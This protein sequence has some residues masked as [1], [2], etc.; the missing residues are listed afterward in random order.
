MILVLYKEETDQDI[1][2]VDNAVQG[3]GVDIEQEDAGRIGGS[4]DVVL[5]ENDEGSVDGEDDK[6]RS[7]ETGE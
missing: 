2:M 5:E 1:P 3:S 4:R 6:R 7:T